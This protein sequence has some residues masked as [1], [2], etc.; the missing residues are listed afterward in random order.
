ML[1]TRRAALAAQGVWV[2]AAPGQFNHTELAAFA[3]PDTSGDLIGED[4]D[5]D[6]FARAFDRELTAL[7]ATVHTVILSNEHCHS[8][9]LTM[10]QV[11]ALKG[12]I[13]PHF[14]RVK[15]LAYLRRQDE[16]ACSA[17]STLL[18]AGDAGRDLLPEIPAQ[19]GTYATLR[20]RLWAHYF[21]LEGLLNRYA[22]V[23]GQAAVT[24]R[25]FARDTLLGGDVVQ[26]F[27]AFCGLDAGLAE[28]IARPNAAIAAD[29]QEFLALL[30]ARLPQM[31]AA[32]A[33]VREVCAAILETRLSG[34]PRLPARAQVERFYAPFR[35][36][37]ERLRAQWFPERRRLFSEDFDAYP[38]TDAADDAMVYKA[39]LDAAFV[40]IDHLV[41]ERRS[42]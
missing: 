26:D 4:F 40:C 1:G 23:F 28:G 9:V 38:E 24:P 36:A 27:L 14:A 39:A 31:Q 29:G 19:T 5:R 11:A 37:N 7:P 25:L 35:A 22:A 21:D 10:T 16:M 32:D 18:R 2:P 41:A 17:Y 13:A 3:A 20:D 30:N 15:V 42:G 12:L 8:R 6:G 34:R 33:A